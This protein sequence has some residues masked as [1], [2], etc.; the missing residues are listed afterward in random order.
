M[1]SGQSRY[2]LLELQEMAMSS[3]EI[4]LPNLDDCKSELP[5]LVVF[6]FFVFFSSL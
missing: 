3:A 6:I 4:S 2:D 1:K 5:D